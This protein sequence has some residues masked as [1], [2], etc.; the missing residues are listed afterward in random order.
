MH[1]NLTIT[2]LTAA[3]SLSLASASM[4]GPREDLLAQYAQR[5]QGGR[6]GICRLFRRA[7]Q[8]ASTCRPLPAASP[9][10]TSCT[11]CHGKRPARARANADRQD[12]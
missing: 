4:A 2:L 9:T 1:P 10:R 12:D 5:C 8:D 7:R 6:P 3:L 11:S